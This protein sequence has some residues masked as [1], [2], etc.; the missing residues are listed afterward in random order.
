[1]MTTPAFKEELVQQTPTGAWETR[2]PPSESPIR[3][4][5]NI[6]GVGTKVQ[7]YLEMFEGLC[8]NYRD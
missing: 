6:D 2:I 1:M 4:K 3:V 8:Q 7:I 5:E